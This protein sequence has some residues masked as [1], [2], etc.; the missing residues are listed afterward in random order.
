MKT[1]LVWLIFTGGQPYCKV[2]DALTAAGLSTPQAC[3]EMKTGLRWSPVGSV[4]SWGTSVEISN[5]GLIAVYCLN[6]PDRE[7]ARRDCV[8]QIVPVVTP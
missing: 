8:E 3:I 2:D 4:T 6:A 5:P 1:F 7:T